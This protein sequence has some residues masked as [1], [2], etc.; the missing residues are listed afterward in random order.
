M[1]SSLEVAQAPRLD[2]HE[3]QGPAGDDTRPRHD[4]ED[5][6]A[7]QALDDAGDTRPRKKRRVIQS[8]DKKYICPAPECGKRYSRAEHLYRHQLNRTSPNFRESRC[9]EY[10]YQQASHDEVTSINPSKTSM[11]P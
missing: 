4:E 8:S 9:F 7:E 3:G 2:Q 5:A 10:Y 6:E 11:K 1:A